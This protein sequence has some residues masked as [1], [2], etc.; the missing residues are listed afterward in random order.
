MG[1]IPKLVHLGNPGNR[2]YSRCDMQLGHCVR[3]SVPEPGVKTCPLCW[4]PLLRGTQDDTFGGLESV[5]ERALKVAEL[6]PREGLIGLLHHLRDERQTTVQEQDLLIRLLATKGT[7]LKDLLVYLHLYVTQHTWTQLTTD[8]K[9]LFADIVDEHR[10]REYP[11]D[12]V[13]IERWW[14]E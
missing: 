6:N 1:G 11:D 2:H 5:L 4:E 9:E 14:R 13:P 8:Q 12:P 10:R 3:S 7:E